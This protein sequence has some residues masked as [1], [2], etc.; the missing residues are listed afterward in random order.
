[1]QKGAFGVNNQDI[2][3]SLYVIFALFLQV[4]LIVHFAVRVWRPG[5]ELQWGWLVYI[6]AGLPALILG[7]LFIAT[8]QPWYT[9]AALLIFFVWAAFGYAVDILHPVDWRGAPIMWSVFIPYV[10]LFVQK[11][12]I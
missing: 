9:S 7:I 4:L 1:M 12:K 2:Y 5:I 6:I 11:S 8:R 3:R 10:I